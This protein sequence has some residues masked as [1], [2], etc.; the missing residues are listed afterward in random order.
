MA[1]HNHDHAHD[2]NDYVKGT[3]DISAQSDTYNGFLVA[4]QWGCILVGAMVACMSFIWG[5]DVAW[6][7]AVLGCGALAIVA[8]LAMKM[9]G[10]FTMTS[11]AI[12]IVGLIAGG[13]STIVGMFS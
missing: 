12:T 5:A 9:G 13:I 11:V 6:L 7:Q 10:A 1:S 2:H 4:S 3:M 8:G